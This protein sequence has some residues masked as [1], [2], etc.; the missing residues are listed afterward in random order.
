MG[1]WH[2]LRP[3]GSVT[4]GQGWKIRLSATLDNAET[5]LRIVS[6][7][8]FGAGAT[9]KR[10]RSRGILLA[11]NAKYAPRSGSG[12]LI[13]IYLAHDAHFA[14]LLGD[15]ANRLEGCSGPYILSDPRYGDGPH[16]VRYGGSPNAGSS[17]RAPGAWR[18][19]DPTASWSPDERPHLQGAVL[20]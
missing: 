14:A 6:E 9:F 19:A 20:G 3:D 8:C 5:I 16:Y 10:L 4:P 15:L 17:T 11:N 7:Y 2:L 13:T 12:K 18:C 1:T